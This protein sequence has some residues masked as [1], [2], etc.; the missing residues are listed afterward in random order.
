MPIMLQTDAS[1]VGI[2]GILSQAD[3]SG[4]DWPI[5]YFSRKL[6]LRELRY[7]AVE[8]ECLAVISSVQHFRVY[9]IGVEFT[10]QTDHKCLQYLH[11]LK[12]E[13]CSLTWGGGGGGA[14]ALPTICLQSA[15]C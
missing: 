2:A 4:D 10:E 7:S 13:K 14:L 8:L 11:H 12:D 3:D 15:A 9:L 6:L 5:A 1:G